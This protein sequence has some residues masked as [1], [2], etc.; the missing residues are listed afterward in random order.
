LL[1][2]IYEACLCKEFDLRKIKYW[3]QLPAPILYKGEKVNSDLKIDVLVENEV[4]IELKSVEQLS[5]FTN[6]NY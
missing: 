6:L 1:E 2:S 3:R 5:L 4:I